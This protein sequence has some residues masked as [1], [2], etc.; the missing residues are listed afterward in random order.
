MQSIYA[1]FTMKLTFEKEWC[2]MEKT[3]GRFISEKR[4]ELGL[5]QRMLAERLNVSFQAISKWENGTSAP[6]SSLLPQIAYI[7]NTSMNLQKRVFCPCNHINVYFQSMFGIKTAS[8]SST[9]PGAYSFSNLI[10]SSTLQSR[11]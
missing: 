6:D 10:I 7:L 4:K 8:D 2:K 5:T 9:A 3:L 11:A 1:A